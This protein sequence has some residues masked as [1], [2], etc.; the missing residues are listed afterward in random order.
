M[1]FDDFLFFSFFFSQDGRDG[2]GWTDNNYSIFYHLVASFSS[3]LFLFYIITTCIFFLL[4][5]L[6]IFFWLVAYLLSL[7]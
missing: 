2:L 7:S 4:L 5:S 3:F 1:A 6:A